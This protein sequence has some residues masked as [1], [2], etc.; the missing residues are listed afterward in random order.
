MIPTRRA[1]AFAAVALAAGMLTGGVG[2]T[3]A[4]GDIS[5]WVS[6]DADL[7]RHVTLMAGGTHMGA[8]PVSGMM[9]GAGMMRGA[10]MMDGPPR[11]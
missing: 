6:A 7:A 1:A 8:D 2:V 11:S 9:G 10:G 5:P 4:R 3:V